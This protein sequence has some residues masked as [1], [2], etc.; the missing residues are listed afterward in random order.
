MGPPLSRAGGGGAPARVWP[1]PRLPCSS[2]TLPPPARPGS[3]GGASAQS[4][5]LP[6]ASGGNVGKWTD[7][8]GEGAGRGWEGRDREGRGPGREPGGLWDRLRRCGP[9]AAMCPAAAHL[10]A[11]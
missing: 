9:A 1:R 7:G 11:T 6:W 8:G 2:R 4:A 3:E 10:R 5:G